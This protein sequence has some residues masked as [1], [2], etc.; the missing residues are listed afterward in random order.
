MATPAATEKQIQFINKLRDEALGLTAA[1]ITDS[2]FK[3]ERAELLTKAAFILTMPAPRDIR[4]ASD[5]ID[6]LKQGGA[7]VL[8]YARRNRSWSEPILN[9]LMAAWGEDVTAWPVPELVPIYDRIIVDKTGGQAQPRV[10]YRRA[11][12]ET[13]RAL[14]SPVLGC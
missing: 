10:M 8:S 1:T 3:A 5:Q 11:T 12:A 2:T 7:G 14:L 6:A 4:D 9:K 13:V